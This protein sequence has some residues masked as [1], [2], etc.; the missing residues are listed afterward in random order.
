ME[1]TPPSSSSP[2]PLQYASGSLSEHAGASLRMVAQCADSHE[3]AVRVLALEAAGIDAVAVNQNANNLGIHMS[4]LVPVEIQVRKEDEERAKEVLRLMTSSE[5]EPAADQPENVPASE[6]GQ[7]PV[8]LVEVARFDTIRA[9]R[10]AAVLLDSARIRAVQPTLVARTEANAGTGKRFILKAPATDADRAAEVLEDLDDDTDED[11][12]RC[13][14][15]GSWRV[16]PVG[17]LAATVKWFLRMGDRPVNQ[18]DCLQ[19]KYRG[20]KAE[21]E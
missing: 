11:D 4:G 19:C 8:P 15:C 18:M 5:V 1:P 3:A 7:P 6:E 21:F 13:P 9:L 10:E 20:P 14:Q 12:F 16:Y 2:H 17:Q